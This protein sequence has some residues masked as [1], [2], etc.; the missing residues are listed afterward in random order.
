MIASL[1]NFF[2]AQ[3]KQAD[4]TILELGVFAGIP[5]KGEDGVALATLAADS[6][7]FPAALRAILDRGERAGIAEESPGAIWN[8]TPTGRDLVFDIEAAL[9]AFL[10]D[11][12]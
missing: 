10:A 12:S 2:Q 7:F 8:L 11:Q 3:A 6:D 5:P 4:L 1:I 9:A